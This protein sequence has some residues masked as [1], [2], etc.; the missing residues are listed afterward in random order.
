MNWFA[1]NRQ[2]WIVDV[3]YVYGFINRAHLQ[4]KFG[5]STPQA[6]KDLQ[7]A[8]RELGNLVRYDTSR[9]CY[10]LEDFQERGRFSR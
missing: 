9:K 5:I 10:V 4:R 6:S 3:L 2:Q 8:M 1:E 7:V